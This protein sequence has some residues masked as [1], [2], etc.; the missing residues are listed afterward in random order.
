MAK[1]SG[2]RSVVTANASI[3]V[4]KNE[5][6]MLVGHGRYCIVQVFIESFLLIIGCS[7]CRCVGTDE[8]SRTAV[9]KFQLH[10]H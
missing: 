1:N 4:A 6:S 7:H 9:S 5:K 3:E 2:P 8:H 10:S